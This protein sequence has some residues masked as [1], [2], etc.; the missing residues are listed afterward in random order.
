MLIGLEHNEKKVDKII[1]VPKMKQ[2]LPMIF[3]NHFF[4]VFIKC[5]LNRKKMNIVEDTLPKNKCH[6]IPSFLSRLHSRARL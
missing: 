6:H 4:F 2:Y 3:E 5:S 1:L